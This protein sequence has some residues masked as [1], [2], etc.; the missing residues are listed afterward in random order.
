MNNIARTSLISVNGGFRWPGVL[1]GSDGSLRRTKTGANRTT[2]DTDLAG[3]SV[4]VIPF[5][6]LGRIVILSWPQI[7]ELA[8]DN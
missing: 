5:N 8:R 7:E 3:C 1:R 4:L 6:C 2:L